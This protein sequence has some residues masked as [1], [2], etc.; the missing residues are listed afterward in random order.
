[1]DSEHLIIPDVHAAPGT[2]NRHLEAVGNLIVE[3]K[4]DVIVQI[5]DFA[6]MHSLCS[7]NDNLQFEG[8]RYREDVEKAI[9]DMTVMLEPVFQENMRLNRNRKRMYWPRMVLTLG[10]HE[11]RI[12]RLINKNPQLEG[13]IGIEDLEYENFGW[14]VHDYLHPVEIDGVRYVH[15]A[16]Q[17]NSDRPISRAHLI[18]NRRY[19]SYT[20]GHVQGLDYYCSNAAN[21]RVQCIVAGSFYLDEPQYLGP[22]GNEH[23]RGV[24]YKRHVRD[25][26]YDPEFIS[27]DNLIWDYT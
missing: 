2:Q 9:N 21:P 22:Q 16:Q 6:D 27:I 14:E 12:T 23:W 3:R 19:G 18:A 7:H 8:S 11:H 25:G 26:L 13:A 24:I 15:Y 4:P 1:M 20:T 17:L 5:G 10:N